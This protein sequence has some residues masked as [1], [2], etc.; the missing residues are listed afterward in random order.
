MRIKMI[1]GIGTFDITQS[2]PRSVVYI[3]SASE[4]PLRSL[5]GKDAAI[6]KTGNLFFVTLGFDQSA[7]V[8]KK[9]LMA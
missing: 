3:K 8:I 9:L 2:I 7:E 6:G 1:T 4:S 5:C